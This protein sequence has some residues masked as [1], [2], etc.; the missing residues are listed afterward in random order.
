MGG[1]RWGRELSCRGGCC[2]DFWAERRTEKANPR[3]G[4]TVLAGRVRVGYDLPTPFL[5][6]VG[7]QRAGYVRRRFPAVGPIWRANRQC[8]ESTGRVL[9]GSGDAGL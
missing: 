9:A 2:A 1:L 4:G 8:L 7:M 5:P 3:G 6:C